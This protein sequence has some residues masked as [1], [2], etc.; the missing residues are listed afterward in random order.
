MA[1]FPDSIVLS[2]V[3]NDAPAEE[4][5]GEGSW[6]TEL[7]SVPSIIVP[8]DQA[9]PDC[10]VRKSVLHARVTT[11]WY[12]VVLRKL[13]SCSKLNSDDINKM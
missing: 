12:I 3:L 4:G 7:D 8:A 9:S 1:K 5:H 11:P 6:E 2:T 13:P 10:R